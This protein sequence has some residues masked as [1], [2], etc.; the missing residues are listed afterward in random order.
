MTE[1]FILAW[2]FPLPLWSGSGQFPELCISLILKMG[3]YFKIYVD[4]PN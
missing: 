1:L 3:Q 4:L 2:Q